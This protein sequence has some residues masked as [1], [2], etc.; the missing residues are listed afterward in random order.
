MKA[1]IIF[2]GTAGNPEENWFPWL[3]KEMKMLDYKVIIPQFPTPK[4]QSPETWFR[5][6]ENYK[7]DIDK[8]TIL[9]GHSLGGGF[10][11]RVL[12]K[13]GTKVK[14]AVFVAA[15][16]GIKP[17]KYYE[18]DRPFVEKP[19]DWKKIRSKTDN[20]LVFHS[21]NDKLVSIGNG[22]KLAK[23]LK[24]ELIVVLNAGHFNRAAGYLK[25]ELMLEKIKNLL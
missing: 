10:L 6:F 19:F 15:S 22:K 14:A 11:L 20:F 1:A 2:H 21:D 7:K 5:V 8:D 4:G 16:I 13:L 3:K 12:E 23:E 17:I 25:F 24:T 9:I 18:T